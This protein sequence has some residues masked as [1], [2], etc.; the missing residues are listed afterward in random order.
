MTG[1]ARAS[2]TTGSTTVT[3]EIR[4]VNNRFLDQHFRLPEGLR[5]CEPRLREM[6]AGRLH[7]G[8]VETQIRIGSDADVE[9]LKVN[10]LRL[11]AL[12][13]ALSAVADVVPD[14]TEPSRL[15]L[16]MAPGV[17]EG[18]DDNNEAIASAALAA[19]GTALDDLIASRG[20][21]GARL[22][23][24][25]HTRV[26]A[27]RDQLAPLRARLPELRAMQRQRILDCLGTAGVDADAKRLEEEL[28][29]VAQR[30]DVD[31]EMDRLAAHLDAVE[32]ALGA[33]G[34]C[35]RRL[36]FLMQ[37]LNR[38]AN[39]LSSKATALSTSHTAVEFKLLIEQMRE[40][41][42]NIE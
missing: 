1:F 2:V 41:I 15:D 4:S 12:A 21:E 5:G 13:T 25:I 27:I 30:A 37:E 22:E 16:L 29:Y 14:A 31:E 10:R 39:T 17:L 38:E 42:Q 36:D 34:P 32:A 3:V 24:L 28:V 20:A 33:G 35:G 40:Q 8:K 9:P 23:S 26:A 19:T 11:R 18:N 7:R 6:V